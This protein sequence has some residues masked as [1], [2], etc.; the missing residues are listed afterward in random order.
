MNKYLLFSVLSVLSFPAYADVEGFVNAAKENNVAQIQKMLQAGENINAK[1]SLGNTALHYATAAEN[2]DMVKF[3]LENGADATIA[4]DKGWTPQAIAEK[5]N[6]YEIMTMFQSAENNKN[7]SDLVE[8]AS[9][10]A[11]KTAEEIEKIKDNVAAKAENLNQKAEDLGNKA[12]AKVTE[13]KTDLQNNI[14]QIKESAEAKSAQVANSAKEVSSKTTDAVKET[15]AAV[16]TATGMEVAGENKQNEKVVA[17]AEP[18][19]PAPSQEVKSEPVKPAPSQEVKSE[20]AKP[21]AKAE[22]KQAPARVIKPVAAKPAPKPIPSNINKEIFAGDEE[23]VYCLYYLGLQTD[24]HNLTFASE[25]FA[26]TTSINKARFDQIASMALKYYDNA[27]EA[28]AQS[29][30][31]VCS[32]IITPQSKDKQNQ[33]IRAMNKAIGY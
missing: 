29:M 26:G 31:G 33:I 16:A 4:N 28:E 21:V 10:D 14:N 18:V 7:L 25:F 24:Q 27:S 22:T 1:N 2:S 3:L 9:A 19:K 15:A 17:Q 11:K 13:A 5:K 6:F 32:K 12:E 8:K 30:A 23:I 20:P